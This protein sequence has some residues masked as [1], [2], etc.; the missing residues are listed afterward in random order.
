MTLENSKLKNGC[1]E[2]WGKET[3]IWRAKKT[4]WIYKAGAPLP[5]SGRSHKQKKLCVCVCGSELFHFPL[6]RCASNW[7]KE[8]ENENTPLFRNVAR[9]RGKAGICIFRLYIKSTREKQ[10]L[11]KREREMKAHIWFKY[12]F[13][14][15]WFQ[16][17]FIQECSHIN[18]IV[19]SYFSLLHFHPCTHGDSIYLY[20][21]LLYI[22]ILYIMYAWNLLNETLE[23]LNN[24]INYLNI[25]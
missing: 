10:N 9:N 8:K 7:I 5:P 12:H 2:S 22:L 1:K 19:S 6:F 3:K 21:I 14:S 23:M 25:T 11:K 15:E 4:C 18:I 17:I 16:L 20:F 13:M 24:F